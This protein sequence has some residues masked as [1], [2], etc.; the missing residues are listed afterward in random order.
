M[1]LRKRLGSVAEWS[2]AL[3]L[4][5]SHSGGLALYHNAA[6]FDVVNVCAKHQCRHLFT[7]SNLLQRFNILTREIRNVVCSR[8]HES[9]TH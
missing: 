4:G 1:T 5:S 8:T 2:K 3:D 6:I 7:Q 9:R